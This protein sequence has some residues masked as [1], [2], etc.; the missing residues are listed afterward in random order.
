MIQCWLENSAPY[1]SIYRRRWSVD[2]STEEEDPHMAW[3]LEEQTI[4]LEQ[5]FEGMSERHLYFFRSDDQILIWSNIDLKTVHPILVSIVGGDRLIS[6]Q[7]R[8]TPTWSL[9]EQ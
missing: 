8:E 4:D 9:E 6:V 1:P 3:S 2:F 7:K 5:Y